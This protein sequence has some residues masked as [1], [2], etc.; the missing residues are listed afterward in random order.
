MPRSDPKSA[1]FESSL[2]ALEETASA[3]ESGDLDLDAALAA[4]ER[5]VRLLSHCKGLL[6]KAEQ[7]VA[8]LTGV[9]ESGQPE[10]APFDAL[11]PA[12]PSAA[13]KGSKRSRAATAE[14][15]ED[16]EAPDD[17]PY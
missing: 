15:D 5:G 13:P 11:P 7:R 9:D 12:G 17:L 10:T 14:M 2:R 8:L 6:D 4:Y 1:G 3:L 16:E